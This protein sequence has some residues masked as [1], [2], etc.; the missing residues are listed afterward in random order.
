MTEEN[1]N[2]PKDLNFEP[3][4]NLE[5][6]EKQLTRKEKRENKKRAKKEKKKNMSVGKR[7]LRILR[8]ILITLVI[9]ILVLCIA[10]KI[11]FP[12]IAPMI[13]DYLV[14]RN[15][16][17]FLKLEESLVAELDEDPNYTDIPLQA[18]PD[19]EQI[20]GE[21]S[22]ESD[23]L[24]ED[25]TAPSSTDQPQKP[26]TTIQTV[27]TTMGDFTGPQL[28]RA[29]KNI[30]PADKTRIIEI[31]QN[32]VSMSDILTVSQILTQDGLTADQQKFIENYLRDNLSV[33]DKREILTILQKY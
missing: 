30:S 2:N 18:P 23:V 3:N 31:C 5:K 4:E 25:A 17:M 11:A 6:C 27:H 12:Y 29:L 32:A 19:T 20:P 28:V 1:L 14:E 16:E 21:E 26:D 7:I 24:P 10:W 13:F 15:A 22:S 8:N 9:L 33:S